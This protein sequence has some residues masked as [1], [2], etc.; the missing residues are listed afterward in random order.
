M[1]PPSTNPISPSCFV[2][3]ESSENMLRAVLGATALRSRYTSFFARDSVGFQ[4]LAI[5]VAVAIASLGGTMEIIKSD[6]DTSS[7]SVWTRT[8]V[9]RAAAR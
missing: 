8:R 1:I 7:A 4:A 9:L 2:T 5:R 6:C 3:F